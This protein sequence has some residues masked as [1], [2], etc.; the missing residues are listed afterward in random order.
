[1]AYAQWVVIHIINSFRNGSISI[2]NAEAMWGKF[3]K[4]GNKDAEIGAG[5]VNKVSVGAGSS[6]KV[7]SCGRSDSASGTEV[8]SMT[9]TTESAP[10]TGPALGVPSRT[11]FRSKTVTR[12][13]ALLLVTGTR[14]LV[15]LGRSTLTSR[16]KVRWCEGRS[17]SLR[18]DVDRSALS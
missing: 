2:K 10:F 5:E 7:S 16:G 13:T 14:T 3:H 1:M 6:E 8:T 17:S 12:T 18:L 15:P 11:T 9:E 4:N